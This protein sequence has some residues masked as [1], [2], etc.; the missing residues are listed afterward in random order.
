[1]ERQALDAIT[2]DNFYEEGL[3]SCIWA[4]VFL[5]TFKGYYRIDSTKARGVLSSLVK[6]NIINPILKGR[7]GTISFTNYGKEVM[8]KLGY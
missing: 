5:D 1:M 3:N 4:D 8:K 6:K 7:D 2:K